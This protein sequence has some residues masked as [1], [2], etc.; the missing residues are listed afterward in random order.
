M[1]D[2]W[3]RAWQALEAE[4]AQ[5]IMKDDIQARIDSHKKILVAQH[6]DL[7]NQTFSKALQVKP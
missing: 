5:L 6:A 2:R 7:R 1:G 3:R 4:L